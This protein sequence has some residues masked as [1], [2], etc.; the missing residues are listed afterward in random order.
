MSCFWFL[1]CYFLFYFVDSPL[2]V[3]CVLGLFPFLSLCLR[4]LLLQRS[5]A[6]TPGPFY[7]VCR[8]A[9]FT[10]AS[11]LFSVLYIYLIFFL[12]LSFACVLLFGF[13]IVCISSSLKLAYC[14]VF[15]AGSVSAPQLQTKA[16][17]FRRQQSFQFSFQQCFVC[18]E[19]TQIS[20]AQLTVTSAFHC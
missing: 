18:F 10:V 8:P 3:L 2:C 17:H 14:Y 7:V 15:L 11:G 4:L 16:L 1:V 19:I 6:C 5:R 9:V 20:T 12:G 13:W